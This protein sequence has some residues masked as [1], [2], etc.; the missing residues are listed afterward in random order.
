MA[1]ILSEVG[2]SFGVR[3]GRLGCPN[4]GGEGKWP[5]RVVARLAKTRGSDDI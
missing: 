2:L 3:L 1:G 5:T 4:R